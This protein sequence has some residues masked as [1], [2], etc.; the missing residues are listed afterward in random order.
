MANKNFHSCCITFQFILGKPEEKNNLQF[1]FKVV[2]GTLTSHIVA[3]LY[4]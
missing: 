4:E 1:R 3:I 2:T